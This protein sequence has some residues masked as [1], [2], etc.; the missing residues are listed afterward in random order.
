VKLS[1]EEAEASVL[2]AIATVSAVRPGDA[3]QL[4]ESSR[5]IPEDFANPAHADVYRAALDFLRRETPLELFA[6]EAALGPSVPVGA[7]GGRAWLAK[8]L[9]RPTSNRAVAEHARLI[10]DASLRRRTVALLREV[11]RKATD[12]DLEP[13]A[14][15]ADG[16]KA[17]SELTNRGR[18]LTTA[19][20]DILRLASMLDDAQ[21]NRRE[22]VVPTGIHALDEAIGGMQPG[23]LTLIGA[24]PGVGK[25]ALLATV[26][27]NLAAGKRKVGF[28]SLEDESVWLARR[29][30]SFIS[31]VP[32]FLLATRPLTPGQAQRVR[33]TDESVYHLLTHVVIDDRPGLTA[34]EVA[35]TATDMVVNQGC[36]A[37]L[38][39][40]LGELRFERRTERYDLDIA[41]ALALL[42]DVAKR[43][44]VPV[45]VA[46]HVR[47]RAGLDIAEPPSLTDFANSSAPERMA[48]VALGLSKPNEETLRVSVLKQTNGQSGMDVELA[49]VPF[50]AMVDNGKPRPP[51]PDWRADDDC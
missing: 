35:A 14:V 29:W 30:L 51:Q 5:L 12:P 32:L 7:A 16:A 41:D 19:E 36:R 4:A 3:L 43:H 39:D 8:L 10:R 49:M 24:L 27:R 42:R 50:A 22:L 1:H 17:F 11:A 13:A 40:H 23:V 2:A 15:L 45:W 26:L 18:E 47:R 20:G 33:D 38:V 25:S 48:R 9:M 44:N 31:R 46:S 28:F 37:I 34:A 6:L 21:E